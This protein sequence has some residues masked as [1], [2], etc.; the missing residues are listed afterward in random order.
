M[1]NSI[2]TN[3]TGA[4]T[5]DLVLY[6]SLASLLLGVMIALVY[7]KEG[8]PSPSFFT[9]LVLLPFLVQSVI[10]MVN[11]NLGTSVAIAGTFSLVRFRSVQGSSKELCFIFFAMAVGL[12]CGT[13]YL[14]FALFTALLALGVYLLVMHLPFNQVQEE[15]ELRITVPENMDYPTILEEVMETYTK[16]HSL[17]RVKS[18]NLGSMYELRYRITL[19]DSKKEKEF[20]DELRIRNG[21]LNIV[22]TRASLLH[23]EL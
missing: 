6:C 13:G 10:M 15:K 2:L 5:I 18:V 21:N 14:T 19:K 16:D 8:N 1:F 20:L 17:D 22:C 7:K 11:G 4:M 12:M 9:T 3:T 23:D